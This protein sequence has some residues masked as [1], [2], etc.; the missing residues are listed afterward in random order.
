MTYLKCQGTS[1]EY[2][3]EG[4]YD[5]MGGSSSLYVTTLPFLLAKLLW[6]WRC[7]VSDFSRGVARPRDW[8]IWV[9]EKE[10]F[11]LSHHP[12]KVGDHRQSSLGDIMVGTHQGKLPSC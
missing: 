10:P 12:A 5:V 7:D 6:Y 11:K 8:D 4:S 2:V 9:Y 1:K 3:I